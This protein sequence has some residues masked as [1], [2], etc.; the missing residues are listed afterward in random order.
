MLSHLVRYVENTLEFDLTLCLEVYPVAAHSSIL[1]QVL[2]ELFV[3]F[4]IDILLV[5]GPDRDVV[6]CADPL[7]LLDLLLD[8]GV[9]GGVGVGVVIVGD[10]G[11]RL[12]L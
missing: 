7:E 9:V 4:F 8:R 10:F 12:G 3:L 5:S 1:G 11:L 2:V 6:V